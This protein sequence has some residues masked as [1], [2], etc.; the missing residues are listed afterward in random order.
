MIRILLALAFLLGSGAVSAAQ[1]PAGFV[2]VKP[3]ESLSGR[4]VQERHLRGA[5]GPLRSE[6]T[7]VLAP[8]KGLIWRAE[9]P[10][11]IVS[12]IT[13]GGIV[14]TI[15]GA[16]AMRL[17]AARLPFLRQFFDMISG[18]LAGDLAAMEREFTV[19]R[20]SEGERWRAV[21]QPRRRD[22]PAA[23]RIVSIA[24]SGRRFLETVELRRAD[25]DG[26]TLSFS[27][28]AVASGVAPDDGK[29]FG[30]VRP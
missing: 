21:L 27:D 30:H 29:L 1:Q 18:A 2:A 5:T 24:L 13:A 3:D 8:E 11:A 4:F 16:E 9:T 28:Q 17:P 25:G 22:D 19:A 6:G 10:F 12:I 20:S 7:F 26:E 15:D 23:G 14:Q